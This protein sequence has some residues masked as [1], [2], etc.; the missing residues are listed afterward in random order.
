MKRSSRAAASIYICPKQCFM[1][2]KLVQRIAQEVEEIKASGLYK[3]ERI[4]ASAQ[5]AEIVVNGSD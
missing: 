2:E 3:K 4:I 1:N 5:G